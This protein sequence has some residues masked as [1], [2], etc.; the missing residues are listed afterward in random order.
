MKAPIEYLKDL[1]T[2]MDTYLKS[3]G[4]VQLLIDNQDIPEDQL[5]YPRIMYDIISENLQEPGTPVKYREKVAGSSGFEYDIKY[6]YD[7]AP[8][9]IVSFEGYGVKKDGNIWQYM[10]VL[11]DWFAI[12]ELS[13]DELETIK[14]VIRDVSNLEGRSVIFS[15]FEERHGFSVLLNIEDRVEVK[16]PT[17]ETLEQIKITYE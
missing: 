4:T 8:L 7:R 13:A 14:I 10:K 9:I 3:V 5:V 17:I 16:V 12:R 11:H 6:T 15:E 1:F 2:P